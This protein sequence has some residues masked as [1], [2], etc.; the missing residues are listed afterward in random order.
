[1]HIVFFG[2]N[3]LSLQS[4]ITKSPNRYQRLEFEKKNTGSAGPGCVGVESTV[5]FFTSDVIAATWPKSIFST[6]FERSHTYMPD[7]QG[8]DMTCKEKHP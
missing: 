3:L 6:S 8:H 2:P 4:N 5:F 7:V 1:M